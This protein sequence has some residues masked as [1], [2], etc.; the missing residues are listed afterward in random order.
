MK[1]CFPSIL[2]IKFFYISENLTI[3]CTGHTNNIFHS[4]NTDQEK[5]DS[6]HLLFRIKKERKA[7]L[8]FLI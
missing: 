2:Y 6:D 7:A 4:L 3:S 8:S 1:V 5:T